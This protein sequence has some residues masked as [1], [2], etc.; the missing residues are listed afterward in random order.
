MAEPPHV[1]RAVELCPEEEGTEPS[2]L[3]SGFG[4]V[5]FG[6]VVQGFHR[7]TMG[8]SFGH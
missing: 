4:A 1:L 5:A 8:L 3:T 7:P 2:Q 6:G